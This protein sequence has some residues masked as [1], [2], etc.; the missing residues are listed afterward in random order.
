MKKI[1][2]YT[3]I[4]TIAMM[5]SMLTT[6]TAQ[7]ATDQPTSEQ[8]VT[9]ELNL[10]IS[11]AASSA[12]TFDYVSKS[13]VRSAVNDKGQI[14]LTPVNKP[15]AHWV[16]KNA[17]RCPVV[18]SYPTKRQVKRLKPT[19]FKLKGAALKQFKRAAMSER[20]IKK[21]SNG[22]VKMEATCFQLRDGEGFPD[23]GLDLNGNV[24]GMGSTVH[25]KNMLFEIAKVK[26]RRA[27]ES[28]DAYI[29]IRRG[30]DND[31]DGVYDDGDCGNKKPAVVEFPQG[32]YDY[33]DEDFYWY[34]DTGDV[35]ARVG[36]KGS[37][38]I[39]QGNCA[40]TLDYDFFAQGTADYSVIVRGKTSVEAHGRTIYVVS[41]QSAH[42]DATANATASVKASLKAQ[43]TGCSDTPPPAA[44]I[45]LNELNDVDETDPNCQGT[46]DECESWLVSKAH[47]TVPDGV[48]GMLR[49]SSNIGT[50]GFSMGTPANWRDDVTSLRLTNGQHDPEYRFNAP[51]EGSSATITLTFTPD[52]GGDIVKVTTNV[53][54]NDTPTIPL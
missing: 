18:S 33:E 17:K 7:A 47:A 28:T 10:N 2:S 31:G 40:M 30:Q 46:R 29:P 15:T 13:M 9:Y 49:I 16:Y 41:K 35:V 8:P 6:G 34:K 21:L 53:V 25:G 19:T 20:K 54:I 36:V 23:T 43:F 48:A 42:V 44:D 4:A 45:S 3:G 1:I 32:T 5:A 12:S 52:G 37:A 27:G 51:T 26:A 24:R 39:K 14:V 38:T 50:V 22:R 11:D